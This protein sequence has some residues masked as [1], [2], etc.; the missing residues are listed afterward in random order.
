MILFFILGSL[1]LSLF[2]SYISNN[3]ST[4]ALDQNFFDD[5]SSAMLALPS[6]IWVVEDPVCKLWLATVTGLAGL[7]AATACSSSGKGLQLRTSEAGRGC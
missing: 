1:K 3:C 5:V 4:S 6:C 7:W 2:C